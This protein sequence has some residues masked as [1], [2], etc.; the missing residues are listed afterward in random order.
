MTVA[1]PATSNLSRRRRREHPQMLPR[2]LH[3]DSDNSSDDNVNDDAGGE[4]DA[5]A[6]RESSTRQRLV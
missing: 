3:H 4:M 2:E 6:N 1:T 5:D